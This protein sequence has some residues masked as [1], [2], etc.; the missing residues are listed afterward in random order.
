MLEEPHPQAEGVKVLRA[1]AKRCRKAAKALEQLQAHY[2]RLQ[3]EMVKP[4]HH[5]CCTNSCP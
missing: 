5:L 2:E 1:Q 4:L 3:W